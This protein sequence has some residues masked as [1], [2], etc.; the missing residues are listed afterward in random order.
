MLYPPW[1]P[2]PTR[3]ELER[4][5][6]PE[7]GGWLYKFEGNYQTQYVFVP[8]LELWAKALVPV[9]PDRVAK[10]VFLDTTRVTRSSQAMPRQGL[11]QSVYLNLAL[12]TST[13]QP[14]PKGA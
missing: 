3:R 11:A 4:V 5:H 1:E 2:H 10:K 9:L 8:S 13:T 6:L 14:T 7:A 12:V